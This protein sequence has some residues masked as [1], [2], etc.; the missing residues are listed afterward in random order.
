MRRLHPVNG[1]LPH[2]Q[3]VQ[4]ATPPTPFREPE[5]E[6]IHKAA[7]MIRGFRIG[8]KRGSVSP[9]A[10]TH[11]IFEAKDFRHDGGLSRLRRSV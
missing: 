5:R 1:T 11:F 10:G 7:G 4:C 2:A 9:T 6:T 3:R 8:D